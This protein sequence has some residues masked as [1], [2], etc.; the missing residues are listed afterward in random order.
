MQGSSDM[1]AFLWRL[2]SPA[3]PTD[4]ITATLPTPQLRGFL[5]QSVNK[6][7]HNWVQ[8]FTLQGST[9]SLL[10]RIPFDLEYK[11]LA[12]IHNINHG[13]NR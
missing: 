5:Q 1:R 3:E 11:E 4:G 9:F 10:E 6:A 2:L 12:T 13:N 8:K 7:L